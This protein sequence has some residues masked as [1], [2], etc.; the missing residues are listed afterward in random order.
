MIFIVGNSRSGTTMLGRILGRHPDVHTFHELHFFERLIDGEDARERPAIPVAERVALVERL[1]TSE[2]ESLF[3]PVTP[4]RYSAEAAGIVAES[5]GPDAVSL[6]RTFLD[7]ECARHGRRRPCE[8]TPRYLFYVDEILA[9]FPEAR[10]VNL[11]RDPRDV[12]LSQKNK[13]R[14][15][16]LGASTIPLSEAIRSWSNFHPML[17]ARLW[18]ASAREAEHHTGR[19]GFL[20]VRFEDLVDDPDRTVR[21]IC[22]F[23][24]L[25]Y[26]SGMLAVPQVG[27]SIAADCPERTGI[28]RD[29]VGT[30]RLGRV[31]PGEIA[32]CEWVA[33]PE[34]RRFG[35]APSGISRPGMR[36]LPQAATLAAKLLLLVPLNLRRSRNLVD[37]ARRRLGQGRAA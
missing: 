8:Q 5:A 36:L 14:R 16:F 35:Y 30:W 4:N 15:R 25:A 17:V 24:G 27:S 10:I 9:L 26:D 23:C 2:R 11:I 13:W 21:A 33:G 28:S 12:L 6:Y 29:R 1:M 19:P 22:D 37:M 31:S 18:V 7:R 32:A 20:S 34:M 3:L